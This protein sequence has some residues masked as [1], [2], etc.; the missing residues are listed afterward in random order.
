MSKRTCYLTM[1]DGLGLKDPNPGKLPVD[2]RRFTG[3]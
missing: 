3:L 2:R 1:L